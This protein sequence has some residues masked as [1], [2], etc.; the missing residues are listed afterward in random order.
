[1]SWNQ[2]PHKPRMTPATLV[3]GA[4]I[5]LVLAFFV[6][7]ALTTDFGVQ[8]DPKG[9]PNRSVRSTSAPS[10]SPTPSPS[11]DPKGQLVIH[12]TG[13]VNLDPS[14]V[15]NLTED[16]YAY[17]WSGVA[18]L[19][20]AD[21]LTIVNLEC[22]VSDRGIELDKQFTFRGDPDAVPAMKDSGV[23]VANLG[24]NH[25]Y[26]YGPEAFLDTIDHLKEKQIAVVGGGEDNDA[27]TK[28]AVF[29][30]KGWK[31]A[32]VGIGNVVEPSPEAVAAP[33]HPGV[34]CND[35]IDCMVGAI[36][37]A[38]RVAD[39]VFVTIHW[40]IELRPEPLSGQIEMAEAFIDAGA[41]AVF[42]HHSHR[43]G[44]LESYKN[45]PIFW[46]LG[47]FVWPAFSTEG[48]TTGVAR[49]VVTPSGKIK[50]RILPAY[51]EPSGHPV[52]RQSE[53]EGDED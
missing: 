18:D 30:T 36:E 43:L 10:R 48:A 35:D 49:V 53:E 1:M 4:A 50:S 8:P 29:R 20:R 16:D 45:R 25:A 28:P 37:R 40:G 14:Y 47:N 21:D 15:P 2:E 7:F 24:N 31:V 32:V 23:E 38:D 44:S 19:F 27:A 33:G 3:G 46:S 5:V 34:A 26:D 22:P 51:I 13:D 52:L 42:G 12:A 6:G 11:P 39:L 41:D 17:P 9:R